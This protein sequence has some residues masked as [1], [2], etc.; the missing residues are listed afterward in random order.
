MA[1]PV[2][3]YYCNRA[4]ALTFTKILIRIENLELFVLVLEG[5]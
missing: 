2:E 3:N 1:A 5:K 4:N